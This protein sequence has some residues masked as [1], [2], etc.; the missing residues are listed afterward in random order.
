MHQAIAT[1]AATMSIRPT[2]SAARVRCR[3]PMARRVATFRPT[4]TSPAARRLQRR[5]KRQRRPK[6]SFVLRWVARIP[7]EFQSPALKANFERPTS[8]RGAM[9]T[10]GPDPSVRPAQGKARLRSP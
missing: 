3:C 1:T 4:A 5:P 9:S 10:L 7:A 6:P 2:R 8:P